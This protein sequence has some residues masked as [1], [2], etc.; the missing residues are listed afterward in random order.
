M[1]VAGLVAVL[2]LGLQFYRLSLFATGNHVEPG[3]YQLAFSKWKISTGNDIYVLDVEQEAVTQMTMNHKVSFMRWSPDGQAM[4]LRR[5][6][7]PVTFDLLDVKTGKAKQIDEDQEDQFVTPG[8]NGWSVDGQHRAV[9]EQQDGDADREIYIVEADGARR[10]LVQNPGADGGPAWSPD[11]RQLAF[12][13]R[14]EKGWGLSIINADGTNLTPIFQT[15]TSSPPIDLAWSP[16]GSR[17]AFTGPTYDQWGGITQAHFFIIDTD[18]QNL[19]E[20]GEINWR[21][22]PTQW[23]PD[24]QTVAFDTYGAMCLYSLADDLPDDRRLFCNSSAQMPAWSPDGRYLAY[25]Q[26]FQQSQPGYLCVK[27]TD[28]LE[29][30]C[31]KDETAG[32]SYPKWR[33]TNQN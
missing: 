15:P 5:S 6:G 28:H 30:H 32:A 10:R 7:R 21:N 23:S 33:P 26:S 4:L 9:A 22:G 16:D 24:G 13:T 17:L 29:E 14:H 2:L 3:N 12:W 1:Q 31:F 19:V 18:G 27:S 11:N 20:L 25:V 8:L